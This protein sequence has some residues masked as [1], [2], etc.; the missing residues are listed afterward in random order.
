MPFISVTRL[1][2]RSWGFLPLF[3]WQAMKSIAQ[4]KR[5][6]GFLSGKLLRN[7]G[8][9]FWTMTAWNDE[10]AMNA[11]RTSGP[12]GRVMRKLINWCDEASV[13]HWIQPTPDLPT[14]LEAHRRMVQEGR[15]SKVNHPSADQ[16][17]NRIPAPE[18]SRGELALKAAS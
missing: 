14:W 16:M 13:V 1:R 15:L 5:S 8:N 4:A 7:P 9:V 3:F 10:R 11:F 12:H 2:V 18:A 17:S 6:P